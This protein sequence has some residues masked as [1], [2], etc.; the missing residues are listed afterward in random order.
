MFSG[1]IKKPLN[2]P[3]DVITTDEW[4]IPPSQVIVESTLGEGAFGEVYKGTLRGPLSNPKIP[5][6]VKSAICIPVAIKML[7][8]QFYTHCVSQYVVS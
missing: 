5:T 1:G 4:E 2:S 3:N 6:A 8:C 7:K